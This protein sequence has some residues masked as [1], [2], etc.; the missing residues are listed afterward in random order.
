MKHYYLDMKSERVCI[1]HPALDRAYQE[2]LDSGESAMDDCGCYDAY[3]SVMKTLTD[4]D[5][6]VFEDPELEETA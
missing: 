6:L 3:C 5:V 4:Y 1:Q 2:F